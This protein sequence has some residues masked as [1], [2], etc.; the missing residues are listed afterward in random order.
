MAIWHSRRVDVLLPPGQMIT[1][2]KISKE[3][4]HY[5][6]PMKSLLS[7][8]SSDNWL[9]DITNFQEE[10]SIFINIFVALCF[11]TIDKNRVYGFD[12]ISSSIIRSF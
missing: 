1:N 6:L 9:L 12:R 4:I 2:L 7:P 11:Y 10:H 5:V 8:E 3:M